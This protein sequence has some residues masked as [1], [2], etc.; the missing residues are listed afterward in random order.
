MKSI[1][2]GENTM[3]DIVKVFM[4]LESPDPTELQRILDHHADYVIDFDNNTDVVTSVSGVETY[5]ENDKDDR[6]KLRILASIIDDIIGEGKPSPEDLDHDDDAI[7]VYDDI[8][9][10]R[11]SLEAMG[12]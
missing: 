12:Y 6:T 2:K 10:L 1:N 4:N 11:Q 8:E 5:I 3:P 7:Q 9:S